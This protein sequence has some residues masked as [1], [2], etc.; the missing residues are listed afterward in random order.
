[1]TDEQLLN[2]NNVAEM[3]GYNVQTIRRHIRL[4]NLKARRCAAY[5]IEAEDAKEFISR[6]PELSQVGRKKP[7]LETVVG[8]K[9]LTVNTG[10]KR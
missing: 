1:M 10:E 4:G 9:K 5:A 7:V 6:L 3:A 2:A 8:E